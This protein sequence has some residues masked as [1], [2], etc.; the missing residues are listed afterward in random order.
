MNR[1]L[2]VIILL[3]AWFGFQSASLVSAQ[4]G[5]T[6][7][8][9]S[10]THGTKVYL[11]PAKHTPEKYGCDSYAESVGA[12]SIALA[13]KN[14]LVSR[15]YIVRVGSGDA[16]ANKDDSNAWQPHVHIPIHS[17]A[18]PTSSDCAGNNPMN[19]G[20]W[21]MWETGSTADQNLAN[22][23]LPQLSPASPGTDD[24]GGTDETLSGATLVELRQTNAP[25]AYVEAAFHTYGPDE[26][27]LRLSTTVGNKIGTGIDS[28]FGSPRC[29]INRACPQSVP[30]DAV[31]T[32]AT[33]PAETGTTNTVTDFGSGQ[34]FPELQLILEKVL[35]GSSNA[36]LERGQESWFSSA[37]ANTLRGVGLTQDGTVVVDVTNWPQLIPGASTSAGRALL[38]S[39][40]NSA[41]FQFPNVNA[42]VFQLDGS[43]EAFARWQ[44]SMCTPITRSAW[45]AFKASQ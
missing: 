41:V 28:Y 36:E 5:G 7:Y 22:Y 24:R 37:T 23:I 6:T 44:E 11:S 4:T 31:D 20:S 32:T 42:V 21:L 9:S 3:V 12:R 17:N 35:S 25:A 43:C 34:P 29:G 40:L 38:F 19:G 18:R 16:W 13:A 15:G 30:P 1:M 39:E 45:E 2:I 14:Y 8:T 33:L 27:W 26:D 10:P